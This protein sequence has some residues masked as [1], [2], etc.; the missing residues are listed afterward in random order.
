MLLRALLA[1]SLLLFLVACRSPPALHTSN[2][3]LQATTTLLW[4]RASCVP[5]HRLSSS[6]PQPPTSTASLWL[7][8][9]RTSRG[10]LHLLSRLRHELSLSPAL[11]SRHV[12]LSYLLPPQIF[13]SERHALAVLPFSRTHWVS[14]GCVSPT[15]QGY[16]WANRR[17]LHGEAISFLYFSYHGLYFSELAPSMMFRQSNV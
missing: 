13:F 7:G 2:T 10:L 1:F 6:Y 4:L 15:S 5:I 12:P 14:A 9:Q 17:P 11:A 16:D 8:V 3:H